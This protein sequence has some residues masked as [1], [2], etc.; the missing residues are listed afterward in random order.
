[1][2]KRDKNGDRKIKNPSQIADNQLIERDFLV[3]RM[4][5][6]SNQLF[7]DFMAFSNLQGF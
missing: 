3:P 2:Q 7:I 6:L 1:V 4:G 5:Q